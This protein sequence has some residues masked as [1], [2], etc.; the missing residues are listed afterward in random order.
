MNAVLETKHIFDA[1]QAK[2]D[3]PIFANNPN[4]TFLDSAASAQKPQQVI[5][6][7]NNCYSNAYANIHRGVY[8]LSQD[9]TAAYEGSREKVAEFIGANSEREIVFTRNA[10]ESIN[11]IAQTWGR[12]NLKAG[13]AI[14]ISEMEHHA[15]IV[16][17]Q[18]LRDELGID[19]RIIPITDSGNI[20]FDVFINLL[21]E[22]VKLLSITQMSNALGTCP[23]VFDMVKMAKEKGVVTLV[24]GCQAVVHM[25]VNVTELD[26]DFYVFSGHKL[27]GPTGIGVLYGKLEM[28]E[29]MPPYQ[30]GGDMI[31]SV[32]FE[33]TTYAPPPAK[34]EA[35][36]PHIAGAVGLG[37][38][39]DYINSLGLEAICNY[40]KELF[41]YATKALLAIDGI[42][43]Y[44]HDISR[45]AIISFSVANVHP[46]DIGT[47]LDQQGVCVR[48]GHHCAQPVMKRLGVP[49]TTR[50]SLGLYNTKADIDHL[51]VA[52]RKVQEI[53]G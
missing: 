22:D 4:I 50:M 30:G 25:P 44:G 6:A 9:A 34:F 36:T 18:M 38:A 11:L 45:D 51:V 53:F 8:K 28:L 12:Q 31:R 47:I 1:E 29:A 16:P 32:T 26:C 48:A 2:K 52:I 5:D 39:I 23:P 20:D 27:Y 33:K 14:L 43:I 42:T 3:F 7:V 21:D 40:E 46:H 49:A 15:N 24:D 41:D 10:T 37:A 19:L 13:D 35:G 17:W